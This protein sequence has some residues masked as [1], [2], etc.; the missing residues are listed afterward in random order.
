LRVFP[1]LS[2]SVGCIA[3]LSLSLSLSLSR[4]ASTVLLSWTQVRT[5][6]FLNHFYTD[7]GTRLKHGKFLAFAETNCVLE[8]ENSIVIRTFCHA[9]RGANNPY[10][11]FS[12]VFLEISVCQCVSC[13]LLCAPVLRPATVQSLDRPS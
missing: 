2:S 3:S 12:S 10:F 7:F 13:W 1:H 5:Q 9:Y 6:L 8:Y 4:F 11:C